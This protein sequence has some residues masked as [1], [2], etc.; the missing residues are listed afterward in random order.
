MGQLTSTVLERGFTG[1][2]HLDDVGLIHMN[3]R[4]YHHVEGKY[5]IP[6]L[7]ILSARAA[8]QS[9]IAKLEGY[10]PRRFSR[11]G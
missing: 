6:L 4:V 7:F 11:V 5:Q 1:H 9:I 2:E 8:K 3:G 10:D